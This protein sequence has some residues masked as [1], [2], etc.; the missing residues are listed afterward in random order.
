MPHKKVAGIYKIESPSGKVYIGQSYRIYSR[1]CEHRYSPKKG[2]NYVL[3]KSIAKYGFD[4]HKLSIL[5]HLPQDVSNETITVYEQLYMDMY[6]DCGLV[7]LNTAPAAGSTKGMLGKKASVEARIKMS[8]AGKGRRLP[9]RSEAYRAALSASLKGTKASVGRVLSEETK[10]KI[11][12]SLRG[13][14]P[15]NKGKTDIY[16]HETRKKISSTLKERG[17]KLREQKLLNSLKIKNVFSKLRRTI[18]F[19]LFFR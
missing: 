8:I 6:S 17:R 16:T 4:A 18:Y 5:H 3:G 10:I 14:K 15:W 9:P 13:N 11:S 1:W 12:N 19:R 2:I 7:L